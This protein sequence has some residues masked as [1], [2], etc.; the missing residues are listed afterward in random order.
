MG[1]DHTTMH[2][3]LEG[4]IAARLESNAAE[5]K[6]IRAMLVYDE[7]R[8]ARRSAAM[9]EAER[10]GKPLVLPAPPPPPPPT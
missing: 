5:S 7:D 3:T 10:D 8:N 9:I 4:A 2:M 6:A 1:P